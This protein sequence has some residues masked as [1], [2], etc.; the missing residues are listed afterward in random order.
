MSFHSSLI[1]LAGTFKTTLGNADY[2]KL[3]KV[4]CFSNEIS[5][6]N[7]NEFEQL[8]LACLK[9]FGVLI[10]KN[11][12][13]ITLLQQSCWSRSDLE[14]ITQI[15][16][17]KLNIPALYIIDESIAALYGTG[18]MTGLVVDLGHTYTTITPI[19]DNNPIYNARQVLELGGKDV[20][21]LLTRLHPNNL[22]IQ[23]LE[24][25]KQ[26]T[27]LNPDREFQNF[28]P[29]KIK[30]KSYGDELWKCGEVLFDPTLVDKDCM[31]VVEAMILAVSSAVE[32]SKRLSLYES[33][34][35]VGGT[36]QI[37]GILYFL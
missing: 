8:L 10:E 12:F 35:L 13:A 9:K 30:G 26:H 15:L 11:E 3:P 21:N 32:P 2:Y 17:E 31:N 36:S 27:R 33:V 34:I 16:F 22:S 7:K 5:I 28:E 37:Q 1:L 4:N 20:S 19:Y 6:K 14:D 24:D 18:S 23:D 25:V 29:I